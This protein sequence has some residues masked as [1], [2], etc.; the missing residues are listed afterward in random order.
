MKV[1][2]TPQHS[3]PKPRP[4]RH[5]RTSPAA[6]SEPIDSYFAHNTSKFSSRGFQTIQKGGSLPSPVTPT[7]SQSRHW[8]PPAPC[9]ACH[10]A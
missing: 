7:A 1:R 5:R 8:P 4:L 2:E 10:R 3:T 9:G 6:R